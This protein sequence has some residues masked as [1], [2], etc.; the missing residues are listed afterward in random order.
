MPGKRIK[1]D[2]DYLKPNSSFIYPLI[3]EVGDIVLPARVALTSDKIS[4]IKAS[5]TIII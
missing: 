4:I 1:I 3:S 5:Y 2:L